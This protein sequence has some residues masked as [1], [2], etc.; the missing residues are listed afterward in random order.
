[1][2]SKRDLRVPPNVICARALGAVQSSALFRTLSAAWEDVE[3]WAVVNAPTDEFTYFWLVSLRGGVVRELACVR[4]SCRR[5]VLQERI[6]GPFGQ[7]FWE[8][9]ETSSSRQPPGIA[10]ERPRE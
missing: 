6:Q 3:V 1:M 10:A 8:P 9:V 2:G 4:F 7:V 5:E